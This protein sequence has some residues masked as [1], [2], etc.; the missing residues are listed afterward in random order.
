[1]SAVIHTPRPRVWRALTL[2][3]ELIRWD[4]RVVELAQPASTYPCT[5]QPV[6]FRYQLGSLTIDLRDR[7]LE[8]IP[9]QRLRS[10]VSLGLF[11]FERTYTLADEVGEAGQPR[12][13]RV[14]LKLVASNAVPVVGGLIDRFDV[15]RF[16]SEFV[17]T[18]LRSVRVW[19]EREGPV[20]ADPEPDSSTPSP[21][22]TPLAGAAGRLR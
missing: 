7:P 22:A 8:V 21:N 18:K 20:T 19:C 10:H 13:T 11:R 15:R 5:D 1:M 2:P 14:S 16:A 12:S 4:E 17:D 6:R 9:G 3:E